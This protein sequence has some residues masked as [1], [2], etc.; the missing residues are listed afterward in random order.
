M[1]TLPSE[2]SPSA[3]SPSDAITKAIALIDTNPLDAFIEARRIAS[4]SA[5]SEV[6]KQ[7][8]TRLVESRDFPTWDC[9]SPWRMIAR[10]ALTAEEMELGDALMI[11][12]RAKAKALEEARK[13]DLDEARKVAVVTMQMGYEEQSMLDAINSEEN[14]EKVVRSFCEGF[15][16]QGW[17]CLYTIELRE[18]GQEEGGWWYTWR[19]AVACVSMQAFHNDQEAVNHLKAI[20]DAAGL[21]LPAEG[22]R[23]YRSCAPQVTA[24]IV[25]GEALP[26]GSVSTEAPHY[27]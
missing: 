27:E 25:L 3:S 2:G 18:G 12:S 1:A 13:A 23:G 10:E 22:V 4:V 21:Q 15:R 11:A 8:V 7:R 24:D 5:A 9:R 26:F 17:A 6:E 14:G 16:K 19:T 20:A